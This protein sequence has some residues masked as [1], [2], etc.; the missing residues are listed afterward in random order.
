MKSYLTLAGRMRSELEA[1]SDFELNNRIGFEQLYLR[2][3]I[4]EILN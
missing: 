1:Y 3:G 4:L 2:N